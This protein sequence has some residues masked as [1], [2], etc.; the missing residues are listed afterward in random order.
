MRRTARSGWAATSS[1]RRSG[2]LTNCSLVVRAVPER[3]QPHLLADPARRVAPLRTVTNRDGVHVR[4]RWGRA[5]AGH[6]CVRVKGAAVV[7]LDHHDRVHSVLA[8]RCFE[9]C[10]RSGGRVT[11]RRDGGSSAGGWLGCGGR[12]HDSQ[13]PGS[14]RCR[15]VGIWSSSVTRKVAVRKVSGGRRAEVGV[16]EAVRM[17]TTVTSPCEP[18]TIPKVQKGRR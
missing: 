13:V 14:T 15:P 5:E 2:S 17:R 11:T 1:R 4:V 7:H 16:G 3:E 12:P 18:C 10:S 9:E 8:T 6:A